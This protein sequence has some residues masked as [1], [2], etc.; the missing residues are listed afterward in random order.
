[1]SGFKYKGTLLN[2]M[3]GVVHTLTD[4]ANGQFIKDADSTSDV[5]QYFYP[6]NANLSGAVPATSIARLANPTL[7]T[8]PGVGD[9]EDLVIASY[10]NFTNI[11]NHSGS[12]VQIPSWAN[13][14]SVFIIGGGGSGATG[15]QGFNPS[16]GQTKSNQQGRG[17]GGG[18]A[19][20]I[21]SCSSIDISQTTKQLSLFIGAGG[22][23][24]TIVNTTGLPGQLSSFSIKQST[25]GANQF[26]LDAQCGLGG[27]L[28]NQDGGAAGLGGAGGFYSFTGTS[29]GAI[30]S[31]QGKEGQDGWGL[32][33]YFYVN[34]GNISTLL[35]NTYIPQ[36]IVSNGGSDQNQQQIGTQSLSFVAGQG[37]GAGGVGGAPCNQG[38]TGPIGLQSGAGMP[39]FVRIYWLNTA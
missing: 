39:G 2:D 3:I 28:G 8:I 6:L 1:M 30:N 26:Y 36:Q 34:G 18:G 23:G 7:Y 25:Q 31:G 33:N 27:N 16:P 35:N 29:P 4:A 20:G 32:N 37:Y 15:C 19:G 22:Q 14:C 12:Q 11:G 17:G 21:V 13:A 9:I 10:S 38:N 5:S 24:S